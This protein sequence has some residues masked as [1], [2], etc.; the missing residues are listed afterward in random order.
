HHHQGVREHPGFEVA[1][2]AEDGMLEAMEKP[3][4][5]FHVAVQWHPEAGTDMRVFEALV[6]HAS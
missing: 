5:D 4:K 2:R 3:G 1:A 6:K